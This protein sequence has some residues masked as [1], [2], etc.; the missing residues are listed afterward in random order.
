MERFVKFVP[1]LPRLNISLSN[2]LNLNNHSFEF[3]SIETSAGSILIYI[4]NYLS[5]KCLNDLNIYK[6]IN[7]NVLLLKLSTRGNQIL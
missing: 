4:A 7:W 1:F 5:Y 3:T 6:K 2:N